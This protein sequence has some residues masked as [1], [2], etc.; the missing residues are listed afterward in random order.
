MKR[1][2]CG[3]R[4][5]LFRTCR[6]GGAQDDDDEDKPVHPLA[7]GFSDQDNMSDTIEVFLKQVESDALTIQV[8]PATSDDSYMLKEDAALM[9]KRRKRAFHPKRPLAGSST[10]KLDISESSNLGVLRSRKENSEDKNIHWRP[11]RGETLEVRSLHYRRS[12]RKAP[13]VGTMYECIKVDFLQSA[14]RLA[15]ISSH[16]ELPKVH[17]QDNGRPKTWDAPDIFVVSLSMPRD[18]HRGKEDGPSYTTTMYFQMKQETRDILGRITADKH[19][20]KASDDVESHPSVNAVRLFNEWCRRAPTDPKFQGRFKMITSIQNIHEL[21]LPGW[22]ARWNGKPV[23]IKRAGKTGFLYQ[24]ENCMEME[25]SFHPFPWATKQAIEYL[26]ERV[27][28]KI[29]LTYGFVIEGRCEAELPERLIGL[30][31]LCFPKAEHAVPVNEFF[32]TGAVRMQS[33]HSDEYD[34]DEAEKQ[35]CEFCQN[36]CDMYP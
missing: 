10:K 15:N 12:H 31:Q 6:G 34:K 4:I 28:H 16:V 3:P 27:F 24:N 36:L 29:L 32:S 22:I 1:W 26:R 19:H 9:E 25:I 2:F 5:S 20:K 33:L 7:T 18:P 35:D 8:T 14:F 23:L 17:F 11:I 13:S 30:G 21:G